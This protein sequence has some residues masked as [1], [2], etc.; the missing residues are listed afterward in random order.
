M[1]ISCFRVL[2][3]HALL[4]DFVIGVRGH[5]CWGELHGRPCAMMFAYFKRGFKICKEVSII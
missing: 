1:R 2:V 5:G 4:G 3:A